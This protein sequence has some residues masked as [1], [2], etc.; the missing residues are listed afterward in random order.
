MHPKAKTPL[1]VLMDKASWLSGAYAPFF[2]MH[3]YI[4]ENV[5]LYLICCVYIFT[6][7]MLMKSF[8]EKRLCVHPM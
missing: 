5:K 3:F 4:F 6:S 2:E 1:P 7:H 8:G